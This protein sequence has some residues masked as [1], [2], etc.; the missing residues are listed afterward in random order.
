MTNQLKRC[1]PFCDAFKC[2]Q[3]ALNYSGHRAHCRWADDDCAGPSCNYAICVREKM[4]SGGVCGLSV[5][6]KTEEAHAPQPTL[7]PG[8]KLREK[9]A[10]RFR[11]DEIF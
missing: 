4:L 5:R 9:L 2:G 3:R 8:I 6:R 10:R 11:E 7:D 1:S